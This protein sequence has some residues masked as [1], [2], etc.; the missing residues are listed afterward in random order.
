MQE[1]VASD[2]FVGAAYLAIGNGD[3]PEVYTTYCEIDTIGGIGE[4]NDQ[5]EVT[6]F[7][8]GGTKQYVA[9]L[10]DGN[11]VSFSANYSLTNE[12]QEQLITDVNNKANRSMQ[13]TMGNDSPQRV[14]QFL[15]TMLSWEID[16]S[17]S[18]KNTIKFTGKITGPI[19]RLS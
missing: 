8:S 5:V 1:Y 6:T 16:P 19:T 4:K 13:L 17:V 14:F 3:S 9:G 18:A 10:S 2:A 15:V 7:C 12:Q 11:E